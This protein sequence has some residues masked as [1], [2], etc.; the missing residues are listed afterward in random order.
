MS[1]ELAV[2][3]TVRLSKRLTVT[4]SVS[5]LGMTAEWEPGRPGEGLSA[6]ELK[7]YREARDGLLTEAAKRFGIGITVVEV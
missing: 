4:L 7:I 3:K 5:R 1:A 6:G 2:T